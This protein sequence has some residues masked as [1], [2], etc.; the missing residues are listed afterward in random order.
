MSCGKRLAKRSILGTRVCAPLDKHYYSGIIK[1]TKNSSVDTRDPLYSVLFDNVFNG[2]RVTLDYSAQQLIGPG[3]QSVSIANLN[4]GQRIYLTYN[5]RE[6]SGTV[7]C[8]DL[9]NDEVV[10]TLDNS[11]NNLNQNSLINQT[12]IKVKRRLDEIRLLESRKSARLQE[13]DTDYS[14]LA[15]DGQSDQVRRRTNSMSSSVSNSSMSSHID[16]PNVQNGRKRRPSNSNDDV[17]DDC[18]A[19]MV[20]MSLSCSPKSPRLPELIIYKCTW[21]GCLHQSEHCQQIEKH[22][23][24]QHLG[25]TDLNDE[26]S[27]REEEFYYT[28][29][30]IDDNSMGSS[31][32]NSS[33]S[34]SVPHSPSISNDSSQLSGSQSPTPSPQTHIFFAHSAPT[35]SH[36]EDH[37]YERR[38]QN[39]DFEPKVIQL[40]N[41]FNC[42]NA[43]NGF[44]ANNNN[45]NE[46]NKINY[47]SNN[48]NINNNT[49]AVNAVKAKHKSL[50][51]TPINIPGISSLSSNRPAHQYATSAPPVSLQ[52]PR[53]NHK[54][55]RLN[56]N[57]NRVSN[58]S[59]G[60]TIG[61]L[62]T[63][64][65]TTLLQSSPNKTSPSKRG[66]GESRKCRK[67]YGMDNRDSWCTQCK[68]KKACTRFTD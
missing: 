57:N 31:S 49:F 14:K 30:E 27:D 56:S 24:T 38:Q 11:S 17:M 28:E 62:S 19:A 59:N 29:I 61:S 26:S 51:S 54:Y 34:H 58:G 48:N 66:R 43:L 12:S 36:L 46:N 1:A 41:D 6:V 50:L 33:L 53:I 9:A 7:D 25:R 3:F 35:F 20:L 16:V 37:E 42:I 22:V 32:S 40:N 18:M 63:T 65:G 55:M 21:P 44:N 64:I 2:K 10:L 4:K 8:H 67:V 52:S 23:R 5:G 45:N 15:L 39:S 13:L 47:N 68:W 60:T